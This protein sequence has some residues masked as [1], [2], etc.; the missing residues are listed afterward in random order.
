MVSIHAPAWGATSLVNHRFPPAHR[1]N[2]RTRVGCDPDSHIHHYQ[3]EVSIHAPAWGATYKNWDKV[4]IFFK[5][6]IHAPAWGATI[7]S[8]ARIGLLAEFQSTHPRGVRR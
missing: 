5:V 4:V 7:A 3:Q 8:S 2:P 6:S 1:F